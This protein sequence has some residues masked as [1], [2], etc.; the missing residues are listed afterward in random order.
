M[1]RLGFDSKQACSRSRELSGIQLRKYSNEI[2]VSIGSRLKIVGV[3]TVEQTLRALLQE[4]TAS[5]VLGPGGNQPP[6][7]A[8]ERHVPTHPPAPRSETPRPLAGMERDVL[9]PR[10][11]GRG[12]FLTETPTRQ[13]NG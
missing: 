7:P 4:Q 1:L 2:L 5:G 11:V 8:P 12:T 6:Q 3:T 13:F 9:I 10:H